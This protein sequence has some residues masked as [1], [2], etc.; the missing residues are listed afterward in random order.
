MKDVHEYLNETYCGSVGVEFEHVTSEDER[1][2]CYEN[3]ERT[4]AE[5]VSNEEKIKALQL[6]IRTEN[7][8]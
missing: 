2:W 8:E 1:L 5:P 6:L 4:M 7:M 3:Y